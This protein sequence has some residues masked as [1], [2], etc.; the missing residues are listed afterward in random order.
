[1][2]T[3]RFVRLVGVYLAREHLRHLS[4]VCV[5]VV[6]VGHRLD[7]AVQQFLFRVAD[8][9]AQSGIHA[10]PAAVRGDQRGANRRIMHGEAKAFLALLE[11]PQRPA[12]GVPIRHFSQGPLDGR[13][14]SGPA[15]LQD[16]IH[17]ALTQGLD[18]PLLAYGSRDEDER[19][20]GPALQR[21]LQCQR[22]I[23]AGQGVVGQDQ[24]GGEVLEGVLIVGFGFD[25]SRIDAQTIAP[26]L[27]Q[28]ELGV[29]RAI[30]DHEYFYA[31]AG[32]DDCHAGRARLRR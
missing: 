19:R 13:N 6:R 26:H 11:F 29:L 16:V 14:Q 20:V 17:R 7:I 27:A 1:L 28:Q 22:P 10:E 9:V 2:R 12:S 30:L 15:V 3:Y 32:I 5:Q 4:A 25:A 18:G 31:C 21:D 23:E 24:V 8:D